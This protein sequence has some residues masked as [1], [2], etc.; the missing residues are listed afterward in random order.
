MI[1]ILLFPIM[2]FEF[3]AGW[4]MYLGFWYL[5]YRFVYTVYTVKKLKNRNIKIDF[6]HFFWTS[7]MRI[8]D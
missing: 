8:K 5:L 1:H 3:V 4:F 7:T 6:W 2:L